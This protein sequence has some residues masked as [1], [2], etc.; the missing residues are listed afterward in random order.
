MAFFENNKLIT[1]TAMEMDLEIVPELVDET[2]IQPILEEAMKP[3]KRNWMN[4]FDLV[5]Y[6]NNM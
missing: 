5:N 6:I 2:K 3:G 4:C 1:H